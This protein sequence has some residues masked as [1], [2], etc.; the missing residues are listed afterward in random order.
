M[1]K[2]ATK[3][4]KVSQPLDELQADLQRVQADF[5]NYRRRAEAERSEIMALAKQEVVMDVLPLLDNLG[6]ALGHLPEGLQT[7]AW[8]QG[9]QQ[10]AQQADEVLK[11]L[12]VEKIKSVG[13]EFDPHL[14]EA[15]AHD[16]DGHIV[17]EELQP[18]YRIG[19]RVIRPAIVKVGSK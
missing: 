1:P 15:V 12:G 19:D 7:D 3:L 13:Q 11:S 6:R 9:V 5:M 17:T 18:G 2:K 8:A 10:V 4:D 14:H 16:G